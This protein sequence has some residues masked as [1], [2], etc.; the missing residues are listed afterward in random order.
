MPLSV[1]RL[2]LACCLAAAPAAH[3]QSSLLSVVE[4]SVTQFQLANGLTFLVVERPEAPV[5]T[6]YTYANVGSVDE[7]SGQT[8]VAHVFEHMAFKGS[9]TLGTRNFTAERAAMEA[10]EAAF[11][12]LRDARWRGAPQSEVERLQAE[13]TALRD[14]A[15]TYVEAAAFDRVL[16]AQGAVGM[17]ASTGSDRTDYFYSLPSNRLELWFNTESDRFLNPVQREFYQERDVVM[18]E[19]RMRT[20]SNPIGRLIEE[21]LAAAFKAHPYGW[22]TVGHM[23]DLQALSRTDA[24]GFFDTYYAASNLTMA[25]VGDVDA[26]EVRA[27]AERY[28]GPMPLRPRPEGVRTVEPPQMGERRVTVEDRAQPLAVVGFHR[29]AASHPD[30]AV[31]TVLQDVLGNGRTS[32][33]YRG[34]VEPRLAVAAQ[35]LNGFPGTRYPTLFGMLLVPAPGVT[36]DSLEAAAYRL[37]DDVARNGVTEAELAR[38][39]ARARAQLVGVLESNTGLART[40]AAAHVLRGDWRAAFRDLDAISAVTAAD[41]QRVARDTFRPTNR[42]VAVLRTPAG[43]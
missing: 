7:P 42:T 14:T 23:S 39:Q 12:R 27:L 21:F 31:F 20:D 32:R 9:T 30:H 24:Q 40:L 43:S 26:D 8:G 18:E 34:L 36:T 28:F 16:S 1:R 10:E 17:N 5:V 3:A 41:V 6:F 4:P 11:Q 15:K 38:A 37:L 33:L 25:I 29:P 19:R 2:V 35:G 13:F 22:P